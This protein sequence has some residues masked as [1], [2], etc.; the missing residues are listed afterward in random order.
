MA[1]TVKRENNF[2]EMFDKFASLPDDIKKNV[3]RV[4]ESD[5]K[6]KDTKKN[7]K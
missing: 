5:K 1:L 7:E 2:G 3:D 4:K 6:S